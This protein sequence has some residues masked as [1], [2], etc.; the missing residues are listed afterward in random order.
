MGDRICRSSGAGIQQ[1]ALFY[2]YVAATR[3]EGLDSQGFE[4]KP[5]A[6]PYFEVLCA[7]SAFS[8]S[9]V[10]VFKPLLTA[11]K[12]PRSQRSR[13]VTLS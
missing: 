13:R 10:N 5:N 8:A 9:A 7:T 6:V 3:L 2:K 11:Y 4:G 1:A 12:T